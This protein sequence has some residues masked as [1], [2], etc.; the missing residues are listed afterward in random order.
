MLSGCGVVT[1]VKTQLNILKN[2]LTNAEIL[3]AAITMSF[4]RYFRSLIL[5]FCLHGD[6]F[7]I[8]DCFNFYRSNV[9]HQMYYANISNLNNLAKNHTVNL[10]SLKVHA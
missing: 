7:F 9:I 6:L 10:E 8:G 4:H 5:G 3:P 2:T 1:C